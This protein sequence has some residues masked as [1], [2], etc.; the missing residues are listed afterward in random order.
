[1]DRYRLSLIAIGVVA[2]GILG[3]GWLV[4][5]QPQLD[6]IN[7]ATTQ[8]SSIRQVNAVQEGRNA[9]LAADNARL[10]EF[11]ADLASDQNEI[12]ASRLQQPLIDQFAAAASAAGVG[13]DT[14]T[15]D[16]PTAYVAPTGVDVPVPVTQ[17]L[18]A[19]PVTI[20]VTGPRPNL[21][22]FAAALQGSTRIVTVSGS[23]YS[24]PDDSAMTI[25][26]TTWVLMPPA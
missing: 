26:G 11:K 23:E 19:V 2:I 7:K 4:G 18:V 9:A 22:A 3:A 12:P 21:E 15:F 8:T 14:L 16:G 25:K 13:V 24:G 5:V 1:M 10:D 17:T 20:T 6:R